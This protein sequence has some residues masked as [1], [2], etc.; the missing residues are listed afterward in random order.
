[1][2]DIRINGQGHNGHVPEGMEMPEADADEP[3]RRGRGRPKGSRNKISRDARELIAQHGLGAVRTLCRIAA[4]KAFTRLLTEQE[5]EKITPTLDQ[6]INAARTILDR[7]VPQLKASE[8]VADVRTSSD[9]S[10]WLLKGAGEPEPEPV[11]AREHVMRKIEGV[12]DRLARYSGY[13]SD[14]DL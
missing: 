14:K 2:D 8:V 11:S 4:G 9:F 7:L 5:R 12:A 1:M 6:R 3:E 10:G 13:D